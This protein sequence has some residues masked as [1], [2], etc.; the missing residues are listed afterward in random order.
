MTQFEAP[1][2]TATVVIATDDNRV[3]EVLHPSSVLPDAG[4]DKITDTAPSTAPAEA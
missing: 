1:R 3:G 4:V 2:H